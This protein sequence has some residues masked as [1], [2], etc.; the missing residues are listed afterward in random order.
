MVLFICISL[1]VVEKF[2]RNWFTKF[3]DSSGN[4][5]NL[6]MALRS[7]QIPVRR[8]KRSHDLSS[9]TL[10]FCFT[11]GKMKINYPFESGHWCE[12]FRPIFRLPLRRNRGCG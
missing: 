4:K 2:I 12:S 11:I 6:L 1:F 3:S 10:L 9:V 7:V 5:L 8:K